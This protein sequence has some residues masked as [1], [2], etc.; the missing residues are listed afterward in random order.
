MCMHAVDRPQADLCVCTQWADL[1]MTYV[2][3]RIGPDSEQTK[4]RGRIGF[5]LEPTS[6]EGRVMPSL[7]PTYVLRCTRSDLDPTYPKGPIH[8]NRSPFLLRIT[9]K[10]SHNHIHTKVG[11]TPAHVNYLP[12]F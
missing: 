9:T 1:K 4:V 12:R 3:G 8:L 11:V 2:Y 6:L 5:I 7:E 10:E